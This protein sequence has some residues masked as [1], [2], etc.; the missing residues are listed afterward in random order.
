MDKIEA[1]IREM[2]QLAND[3]GVQLRPHIK[4][5][6]SALIAKWQTEAG[7]SGIEVG[8]IDQAEALAEKGFNNI[9][10]AHPFY[11]NHK[12]KKLKRLLNKSENNI[13]VVVDMIEQAKSISQ[14]GQAIGRK[15]PIVLKI[16]TGGNR[17][18]V[19]PGK[20][21]LNLVRKLRQL[22]GIEFKGIYTQE[23]GAEPTEEGVDKVAFEVA[24]V[25]SMTAKILKEENIPIEHVSVGASPT[26]RSTCRYIR[27]GKFPEITEIHPGSCIIGSVMHINTFATTED[28]C[29][30]TVLV[31]V[32]STSHS[33]HAVIDAGTKTF[34]ADSLIM[35]RNKPGFFW[36]GMPSFGLVRGRPDLWLGALHAETGRVFYKAPEEKLSIGERLEIIPNNPFVVINMHNKLYGVRSGK[37][38]TVIPVTGRCRG[39]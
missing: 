2:S 1:N 36:K 34:G 38:E 17:Y 4:V 28:K 15:V 11:G 31:S 12:M 32:M 26:F 33:E 20:L 13:T 16:E 30:L 35:F 5:H 29:A 9:L 6:E 7:A 8:P 25:M 22:L 37:V 10:I 23:S 21:T 18:G 3:A 19:L 14:V 24:S 27:E 39:S